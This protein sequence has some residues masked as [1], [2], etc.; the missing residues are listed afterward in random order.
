MVWNKGAATSTEKGSS[1]V[2]Y[3][4]AELTGT[5]LRQGMARDKLIFTIICVAAIIV[6]VAALV[7]FFMP[8]KARIIGV[9][10]QCLKCN[11]EF[12]EKTLE[13]P[14]IACPKCGGQAVRVSYRKCPRCGKV[15]LESRMRLTEQSQTQYQ[16][17]KSQQQNQA[18]GGPVE[19]SARMLPME[20]EY[21]VKQADGNYGWSPWVGMNTPKAQQILAGLECPECG[22]Q[23]LQR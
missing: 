21:R 18:R 9:P 19:M 2:N 4:E 11:Y 10:W 15:I 14:P 1:Y 13:L 23:L 16:A 5:C 17:L 6:A 7:S 3:R 12:N 8:R 22:G 20:V